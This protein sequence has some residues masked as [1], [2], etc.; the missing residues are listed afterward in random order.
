MAMQ[1]FNN[2]NAS[3]LLDTGEGHQY[4]RKKHKPSSSAPTGESIMNSAP[5]LRGCFLNQLKSYLQNTTSLTRFRTGAAI[6][7]ARLAPSCNISST[8][9]KCVI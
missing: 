2:N 9:S 7:R 8:S 5:H 1:D 3:L 4:D 6:S